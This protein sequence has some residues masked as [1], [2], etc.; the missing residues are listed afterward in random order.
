MTNPTSNYGWQMPTSTDL[1]TDLPADFEV[2]G[3]AN[4]TTI[5]NL[6][7]ETT[8]GDI[9]YRSAT[10]NVNTRLG[11]GSTGQVMTVAGGVP[12]WATPVAGGGITLISTTTMSGATTT[13]SSINQTY[14]NLFMVI[15]GVTGSSTSRIAISPNASGVLTN[16]QLVRNDSAANGQVDEQIPASGLFAINASG[17][18][19]ASYVTINNYSSSTSFKPY[20][21]YGFCQDNTPA[22]K[23][24]F[25]GGAF[26]STSAIT[27]LDITYTSS[28]ATG[29][30]ILLYGEK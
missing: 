16:Y 11:I 26:R 30:T 22:N 3:Q 4:D 20:F 1:V 5:K 18:L 2:F 29:G 8:L 15:F 17:G 19:N 24:F 28:S 12:T 6:N 13:I 14:V 7:P 10:A 9:A 27:S 25:S 23:T 21:S